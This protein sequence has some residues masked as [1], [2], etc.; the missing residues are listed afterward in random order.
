MRKVLIPIIF[1][2]LLLLV[3]TSCLAGEGGATG[4]A[5][6]TGN[7]TET[8]KNYYRVMVAIKE[9]FSV[10]S[11]NPIDVEEG[12]DAVFN[13]EIAPTH[14]FVSVSEGSYDPVS[15]KLTVPNVS[16]KL[17]IDFEVRLIPSE[18]VGKTYSYVFSGTEKDTTSIA[19][20]PF[21]ATSFAAFA[22]LS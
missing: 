9:G 1:F 2:A 10:T 8:P 18:E 12:T 7:E 22:I 4:S 5:P 17:F 16:K 21:A 19:S 13:I 20:R 15:G 3:L 14:A 6:E 11:D